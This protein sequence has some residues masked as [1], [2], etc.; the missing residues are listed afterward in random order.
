MPVLRSLALLSDEDMAGL[1]RW[2]EPD[3]TNTR[4]ERVGAVRA[5]IQLEACAD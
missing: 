3:I 5:S 2:S 4:G 1:A